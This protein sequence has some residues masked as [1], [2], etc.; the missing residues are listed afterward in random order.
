MSEI[1]KGYTMCVEIDLKIKKIATI[2]GVEPRKYYISVLIAYTQ[3]FA[4]TPV[5]RMIKQRQNSVQWIKTFLIIY[6]SS[7]KNTGKKSGKL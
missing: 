1:L 6:L 7:L 5:S 3:I 4:S 2:P